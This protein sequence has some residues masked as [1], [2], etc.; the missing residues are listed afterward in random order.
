M[1]QRLKDEIKPASFPVPG[2]RSPVSRPHI[3]LVVARGEAVRNFLYSDT[4]P[5]LAESAR[6][7]LL[8]LV[9]HGEVVE[10]VRPYVENIIPL[11]QYRE[12]PLVVYF[13]QVLHTA[14]YRWLWS[15]AVKYYWGRHDA[16]VKGN[17]KETP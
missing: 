5:V 2:P 14:H 12:N 16:R 11:R 9:D 15:E 8:S 1:D 17:L 7:T 6:V 4:L 13:R 10:S 3:V